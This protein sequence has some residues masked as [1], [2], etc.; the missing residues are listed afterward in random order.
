[1]KEEVTTTKVEN[2]FKVCPNC[3]YKNGFH[4]MFEKMSDNASFSWKLICPNCEKVF[5]IGLSVHINQDRKSTRLNSSH[6][7]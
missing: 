4:A 5:D 2:V 1:M 7:Q 3:G 6:E